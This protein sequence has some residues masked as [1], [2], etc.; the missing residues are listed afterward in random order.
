MVEGRVGRLGQG[1]GGGEDGGRGQREDDR[2]ESGTASNE[3][4]FDSDLDRRHARKRSGWIWVNIRTTFAPPASLR[5]RNAVVRGL[6][7]LLA[8][9][10]FHPEGDSRHPSSWHVAR[11]ELIRISG[12]RGDR[13]GWASRISARRIPLIAFDRSHSATAIAR[14]PAGS[15]FMRLRVRAARHPNAAL[16]IYE[17]GIARTP[18][19]LLSTRTVSA[20]WRA[21]AAGARRLEDIRKAENVSPSAQRRN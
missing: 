9:P 8:R 6:Q 12:R 14:I 13:W 16:E 7:T 10:R 2:F 15:S 20:P 11:S 21:K 19:T 5:D 4:R 1:F 3:K 17:R 18:D